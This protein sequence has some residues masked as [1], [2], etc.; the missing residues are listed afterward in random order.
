MR[1]IVDKCA[2]SYTLTVKAPLAN[3]KRKSIN[4]ILSAEEYRRFQRYCTARGYKKSTLLARLLRDHLNA[5]KF[6]IQ[7]DLP[8][9][10]H[11]SDQ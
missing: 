5:E 4:V 9:E 3:K 11:K 2:L 7:T 6:T 1:R 10:Q 8:L